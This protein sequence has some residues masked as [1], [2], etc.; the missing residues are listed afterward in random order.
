MIKDNQNKNM[1]ATVGW[2]YYTSSYFLIVY[3]HLYAYFVSF[4]KIFN[5]FDK[6]FG[7][8]QKSCKAVILR[9]YSNYPNFSHVTQN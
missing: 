1:F 5:I 8:L 4:D 6:S 9:I 3:E 2:T 7:T